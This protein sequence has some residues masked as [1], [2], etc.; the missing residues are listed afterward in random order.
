DSVRRILFETWL[1]TYTF[2]PETDLKSHLEK[3]YSIPELE[4]MLNSDNVTCIL[5]E[6]G[7]SCAFMKLVDDKASRRFYVSSLYVLPDYQQ[8]GMG[9]RLMKIA[10]QYALKAQHDKTWLGVMKQNTVALQW[11]KKTGFNFLVLNQ[12][13]TEQFLFKSALKF[14]FLFVKFCTFN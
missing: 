12:S 4:A 3:F 5:A 2:I 11:Y 10:V 9:S 6:S 7:S 1:K 8:F 14:L 13:T